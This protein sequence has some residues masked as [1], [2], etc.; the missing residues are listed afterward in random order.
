LGYYAIRHLLKINCPLIDNEKLSSFGELLELEYCTL[1]VLF[2][3][4]EN[5]G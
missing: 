3:S 2:R 5:I 1:G 4:T